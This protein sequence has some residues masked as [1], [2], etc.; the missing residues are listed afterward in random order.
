MLEWLAPGARAG[1][2]AAF[3]DRDG[4]L[5]EH[6]AGGYVLARE[7]FRWLPGAVDSMRRLA[8]SGRTLIVVTNQSCINRGLLD[9]RDFRAIMRETVATLRAGGAACAAWLCCPHRP[10]EGCACR[11]PGSLMLER[12]AELTGVDLARSV[13]IGDS[14]SD[15]RA[16]ER[17]GTEGM[18]IE[19]NSPAAFAEAVDRVTGA[20][21]AR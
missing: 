10:D 19:R 20:G 6:I 11:K 1:G 17:V 13:L 2:A 21:R 16:A 7:D 12:A 3:V 14:P 5:N 8:E 18:L 15:V 4:V 9:E